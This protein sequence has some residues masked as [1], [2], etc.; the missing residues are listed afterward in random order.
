[1]SHASFDF[2]DVG[3]AYAAYS[4]GGTGLP[5]TAVLREKT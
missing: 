1:M 5:R 2:A 4:S 3:G